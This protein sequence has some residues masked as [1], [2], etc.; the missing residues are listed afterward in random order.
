MLG[1]QVDRKSTGALL[2]ALP[3]NESLP[4]QASPHELLHDTEIETF[5]VFGQPRQVAL[6]GGFL[7]WDTRGSDLF[8]QGF[9]DR[10]HFGVAVSIMVDQSLV[11]TLDCVE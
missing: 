1:V 8:L 5:D 3:L 11:E 6:Q 2:V 9:V 7:V 10:S 4:V